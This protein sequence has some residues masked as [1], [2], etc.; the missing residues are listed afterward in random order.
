MSC[1]I[2]LYQSVIDACTLCEFL[3]IGRGSLQG[4]LGDTIR[5][6]HFFD[7]YVK[8][9]KNT[10][11]TKLI[12]ILFAMCA[13]IKTAYAEVIERIQIGDLYYDL[14]STYLTAEVT[15]ESN[16]PGNYLGLTMVTI[17]S[18]VTHNDLAYSV[19][20]IGKYAFCYCSGLTSVTI[21]NS[22]TRIEDYSFAECSG[23][24]SLNIPNNVTSIGDQAF[25][26]CYNLSSIEM[27]SS[28]TSIGVGAFDG[29]SN[30]TSVEIP[31][32]I[33]SIG[34]SAFR[35]CTSLTY[36][37]IPNSVTSI[38]NG[39]FYN[40]TKLISINVDIDNPNYCS[41]DDVLFNK[42]KTIL[43]Q[44]PAGKLGNYYAIPKSVVSI[45]DFAF[46]SNRFLKSASVPKGVLSIG[47]EAFRDCNSLTSI[48]IP[49][50]VTSIGELAF[51]ECSSLSSIKIPNSV[52]SIAA[53]VFGKC[54]GLNSV[55]IPS[56][57]T[58]IGYAAF[59]NCNEL[60]YITCRS[61]TPP[62]LGSDVFVNVIKSIPLYVPA[63][64][65]ELYRAAEQWQDF[66]NI[67]ALEETSSPV[68]EVN[69]DKEYSHKLLRN[70]QVLI[71]HG[72]KTYTF[73]GQE[74]K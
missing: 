65:I 31:N 67:S 28:V 57:I 20:S 3:M 36:I 25:A 9:I 4:C 47:K 19:T 29:C 69:A 21:P 10:M 71:H 41:L 42:D 5:D 62:I 37:E 49:N 15:R 55:E 27:S 63:E 12:I 39:A 17:P 7:S 56:S 22:V 73:Q 48:E 6:S 16:S 68:M 61:I 45:E 59:Y 18:S 14:N 24:P 54:S 35:D 30:L 1:R 46:I 32:S 74:V 52:T 13:S 26:G 33:T 2:Y 51:C 53:G 72:G 66:Y 40:C 34:S 64:S 58:S 8:K 70:G 44:Y 60:K 23:L 11:K 43:V 38:G 50:S